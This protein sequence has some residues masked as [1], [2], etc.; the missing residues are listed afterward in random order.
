MRTTMTSPIP[1]AAAIAAVAFS[2]APM[3][4]QLP[5]NFPDSC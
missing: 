1:T 4:V 2:S 3:F 5:W